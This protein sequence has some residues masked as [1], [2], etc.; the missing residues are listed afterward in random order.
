MRSAAPA[1][2]S[3]DGKLNL[4]AAHEDRENGKIATLAEERS[5]IRRNKQTPRV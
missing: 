3:N 4:A 2:A 1:R 5:P